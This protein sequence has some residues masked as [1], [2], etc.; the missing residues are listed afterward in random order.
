M[1]EKLILSEPRCWSCRYFHNPQ[2]HTV[3]IWFL[4]EEFIGQMQA[5]D[6]IDKLEYYSIRE[7]KEKNIQLAFP[8]DKLILKE[9][10]EKRIL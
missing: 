5:G 8:T 7:I 9:L 2:Q 3:G 4:A 10:E 1:I 6:D